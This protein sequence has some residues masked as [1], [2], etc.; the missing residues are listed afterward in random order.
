VSGSKYHWC[1]G[2]IAQTWIEHTVPDIYLK[3][4]YAMLTNQQSHWEDHVEITQPLGQDH[5]LSHC[6]CQHH[7]QIS[8]CGQRQHQFVKNTDDNNFHLKSQS[9]PQLWILQTW[10][11]NY[12]YKITWN[13]VRIIIV[14]LILVV[15]AILPVAELTDFEL[16]SLQNF[17]ITW[18]WCTTLC[19]K[20]MGTLFIFAI[21]Q[22][23]VDRS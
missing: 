21:A 3:K 23:V 14:T 12:T 8:S 17:W 5:A 20:K 19:F 13:S 9:P 10:N 6:W 22:F 18:V 15:I 2:R 4:L 11:S 1:I 16:V 7:R